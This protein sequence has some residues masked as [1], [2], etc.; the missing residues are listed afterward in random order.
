[1]KQNGDKELG[2]RATQNSFQ[3]VMEN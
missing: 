3:V 1:V 2:D